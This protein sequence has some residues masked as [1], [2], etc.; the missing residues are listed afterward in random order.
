MAE[1]ARGTLVQL[2]TTLSEPLL[3]SVHDVHTGFIR[4]SPAPRSPAPSTVVSCA[5]SHCLQPWAQM[6]AQA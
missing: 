6:C 1:L 3:A 2:F 4:C 5:L